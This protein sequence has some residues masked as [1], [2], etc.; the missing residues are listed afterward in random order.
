[1]HSRREVVHSDTRILAVSFGLLG[2]HTLLSLAQ[3]YL[4]AASKLA[5]RKYKATR[6][7]KWTFER[8]LLKSKAAPVKAD[9]R[10]N[11]RCQ[12]IAAHIDIQG[13]DT[14]PVNAESVCLRHS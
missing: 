2:K 3:R 11:Q 13:I 7:G 12:P 10:L 14:T 5:C 1:V 9:A 8:N 6:I 4:P